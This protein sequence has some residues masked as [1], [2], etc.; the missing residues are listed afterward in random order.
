MLKFTPHFVIQKAKEKSNGNNKKKDIKRGR[1]LIFSSRAKTPLQ[2]A[3]LE[4]ITQ[5]KHSKKPT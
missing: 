1:I 3:N 2:S 5:K 4:K